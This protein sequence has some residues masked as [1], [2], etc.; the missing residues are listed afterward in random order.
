[1]HEH[2]ASFFDEKSQDDFFGLGVDGGVIF[3]F[4][5]GIAFLMINAKNF[6]D[7]LG[8]LEA[9]EGFVGFG[10]DRV[11]EFAGGQF[12]VAFEIDAADG[13]T[14]DNLKNHPHFWTALGVGGRKLFNRDLNV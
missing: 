10:G 8:G 12:H 6:L 4:G 7:V 3:N 13:R 11:A 9:I 2:A 14:L 5:V 1:M